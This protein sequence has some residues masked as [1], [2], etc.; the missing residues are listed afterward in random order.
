MSSVN[1]A[2]PGPSSVSEIGSPGAKSNAQTAIGTEV[3]ARASDGGPG[4]NRSRQT[5]RPVGMP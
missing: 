1:V 2:S 4:S 3:G 5:A